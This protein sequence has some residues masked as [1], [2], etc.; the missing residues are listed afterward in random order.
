M[1]TSS[2]DEWVKAV[3]AYLGSPLWGQGR[4]NFGGAL[5]ATGRRSS[6]GSRLFMEVFFFLYKEQVVEILPISKAVKEL[7]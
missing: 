6:P 2:F 5:A 3:L 1:S 4:N 7:T